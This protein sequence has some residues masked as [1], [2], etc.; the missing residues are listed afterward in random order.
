VSERIIGVMIVCCA[1]AVATLP[2]IDGG[3]FSPHAAFFAFRFRV[4]SLGE[5]VGGAGELAAA[6]R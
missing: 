3:G 6:A 2:F 4:A 1:V 5:A